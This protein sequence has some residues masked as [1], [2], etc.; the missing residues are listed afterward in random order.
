MKALLL[1]AA[2]AASQ[3]TP[4]PKPAPP[5]PGGPTCSTACARL[6]ALGCHDGKPT[7]EGASCERVCENAASSPVPLP[8]A[9]VTAARDCEEAAQCGSGQ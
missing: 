4:E 6:M 2:L 8:V 5:P 9:C 3:C 7:E 1:V